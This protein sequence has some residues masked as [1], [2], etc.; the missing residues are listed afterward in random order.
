MHPMTC[1]FCGCLGQD[2]ETV[3]IDAGEFACVC[4]HCGAIGPNL[5][6]PEMAVSHWNG[7]RL[8]GTGL[9]GPMTGTADFQARTTL[10]SGRAA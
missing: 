3:E 9:A 5:E 8:V 10:R 1:P 4:G 7:D 6:S 2:V